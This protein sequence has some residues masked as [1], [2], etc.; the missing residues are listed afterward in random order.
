MDDPQQL[1]ACVLTPPGRGAV[2][3]IAVEGQAALEVVE[4]FFYPKSTK[5]SER[6]LNSIA[7]GRWGTEPAEDVVA[8]RRSAELIEIHCHGGVAAVNRILTDLTAAGAIEEAWQ[9]SIERHEA[10]PIRAAARVALS[11]TVTERGAMILLDQYH[12]VLDEAIDSVLGD[13]HGNQLDA[14]QARLDAILN[15]AALGLHL[16][17]PWKVVIAGPPNV[18]KSSL[19]N[20]LLGYERAIV[21]D[22]PGTTRDVVTAQTA[23]DGWPVQLADTAGLR[24]SDDELESAGVERAIAQAAAADC[25]LLIFDASQPWT[26]ENNRLIK[27]WPQ[28]LVVHNKCDLA[29]PIVAGLR[30][31]ALTGA[32]ISELIQ[33]IVAWIVPTVPQTGDAVPFTAG[34]VE[35]LQIAAEQLQQGDV[36]LAVNALRSILSVRGD[37]GSLLA[38]RVE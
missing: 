28:A 32:G 4:R 30:M 34:Q 25:L 23:F 2:A 16:T 10:S 7:Y 21:F 19:I 6:A 3:V 12:G 15:Y 24:A 36:S 29:A 20:A 22:Q 37:D 5:L 35:A 18:G 38:R 27:K 1:V 9:A 11:Q 14:A 33:A 13:L 31:S 8:C 26:V 17:Q